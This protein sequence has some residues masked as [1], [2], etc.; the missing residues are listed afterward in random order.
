VAALIAPRAELLNQAVA[1]GRLTQEQADAMLEEMTE[2]LTEQ[3]ENAAVGGYGGG[4]GMRAGGWGMPGGGWGMQGGAQ[5]YRG[6]R[7][8]RG[9]VSG[10]GATALRSRT[11]SL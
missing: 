1:D 9:G 5:G 11:N 2:H 4:C 8:M 10:N 3:L 6:G 7:G